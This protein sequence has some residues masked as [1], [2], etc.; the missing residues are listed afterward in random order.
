MNKNKLKE[1]IVLSVIFVVYNILVFV[2]P[3][4]KNAVFFIVY[5]FTVISVIALA[6]SYIIAFEKA[7]TL[8]SKF[9]G[10]PIFKIGYMYLIIQLILCFLFMAISSF[11]N[12]PAW[13]AVVPC[14]IIL[15]IA[16]ISIIAVDTARETIVN[17]G[18]KQK[19]D[20]LFMRLLQ[21]DI[22][23]LAERASDA[24]IKIKL[25]ES[26]ETVKYSDPVSNERL[27]DIETKITEVFNEIKSNIN[28]ENNN[29]EFL[30]VEL[31]NLLSERNKKCKILKQ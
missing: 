10:F 22:E 20:M 9:L 25:S 31:N 29:L 21:A 17:I 16:V 3:F 14:V 26:A 11:A 13:I 28:T 6:A 18:Q 1:L 4:K 15:G 12:I 2:I 27:E 19:S 7:K 24:N 23:T 5:L 8:K 30:I